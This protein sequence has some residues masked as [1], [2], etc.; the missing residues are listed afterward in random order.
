MKM[1][2]IITATSYFEV[3]VDNI[4]NVIMSYEFRDSEMTRFDRK[5]IL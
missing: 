1:T 3:I 2:F 4:V 5:L